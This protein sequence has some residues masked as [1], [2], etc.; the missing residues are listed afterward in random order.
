M[1][2]RV[3]ELSADHMRQQREKQRE[4]PAT[5][6]LMVVFHLNFPVNKAVWCF[7][8]VQNFTEI[9]CVHIIAL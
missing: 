5:V 6:D 9:A 1:R 7:V 3:A 8:R 2:E 4:P